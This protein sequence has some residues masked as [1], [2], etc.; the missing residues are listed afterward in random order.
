MAESADRAAAAPRRSRPSR[1]RACASQVLGRDVVRPR[2]L[3]R[4]ACSV[5]SC[6]RC[7]SRSQT[8]EDEDGQHD[9]LVRCR[10]GRFVLIPRGAARPLSSPPNSTPDT[11]KERPSSPSPSHTHLSP[12][13]P[14]LGLC[15][16]VCG[17]CSR[18]FHVQSF[19]HVFQVLI[20]LC[21]QKKNGVHTLLTRRC[22]GDAQSRPTG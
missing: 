2:V 20:K 14:S 5:C 12:A 10:L 16:D 8:P 22:S 3:A 1:A 17:Y 13:L 6:C 19:G 21:D 11:P 18:R 4:H 15:L 7:V 9:A